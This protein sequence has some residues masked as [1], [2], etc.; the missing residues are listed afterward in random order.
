M[1]LSSSLRLNW[2][3]FFMS[4]PMLKMGFF[5]HQTLKVTCKLRLVSSF[6]FTPQTF[7][8][9]V[10]I[11]WAPN[12]F[13]TC[14]VCGCSFGQMWSSASFHQDARVWFP[15]RF[16]GVCVCPE[17]LFI[18]I[19]TKQAAVD[20]WSSIV[21]IT[22]FFRLCASQHVTLDSVCRTCKPGCDLFQ[23]NVKCDQMYHSCHILR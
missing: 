23:G 9:I 19:F 14:E 20:T 10:D 21:E 16:E 8:F 11:P 13:V 17:F 12:S 6:K 4:F 1:Q 2:H 3:S 15:S 5:T 7:L 22:R 18:T